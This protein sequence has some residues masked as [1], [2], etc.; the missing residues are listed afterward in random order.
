M[1][2]PLSIIQERAKHEHS[3]CAL[4]LS[5]ARS[6]PMLA[7]LSTVL[8]ANACLE[9]SDLP[10]RRGRCEAMNMEHFEECDLFDHGAEQIT[11]VSADT[12]HIASG[13]QSDLSA[14]MI[15][16]DRDSGRDA[17]LAVEL[18]MT[19]PVDLALP[20]D[21]AVPLDMASA[22]DPST[23][24]RTWADVHAY[25]I[26]PYCES[27]H[28]DASRGGGLTLEFDDYDA[29]VNQGMR[30]VAQLQLL[31]IQPGDPASSY[32]YMKVTGAMGISASVMPPSSRLSE[33]YVTMLREW[34]ERG[35]PP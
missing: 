18:D 17:T 25:I 1:T 29:L 9:A 13:D 20:V 34:I 30:S 31:V 14:D 8:W 21:I 32:L 24:E 19:L 12:G 7:L 4:E 26:T 23:L 16:P 10:Q 22:P 15:S 27:C 6:L 11:E 5:F 3:G 28:R 33:G 35:A 2:R